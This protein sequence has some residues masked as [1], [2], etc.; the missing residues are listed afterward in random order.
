MIV[1]EEEK[2]KMIFTNGYGQFQIPDYWLAVSM[3]TDVT[4]VHRLADPEKVAEAIT[5]EV[6]P[7]N[8]LYPYVSIHV[9]IVYKMIWFGKQRDHLIPKHEGI[10]T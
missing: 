8:R 3:A 4:V 1:S 5:I 9:I 7:I 2:C 10:A 6:Q